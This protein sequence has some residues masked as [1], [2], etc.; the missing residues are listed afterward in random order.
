M[1]TPKFYLTLNQQPRSPRGQ[2]R[3][4]NPPIHRSPSNRADPGTGGTEEGTVIPVATDPY[5]GKTTYAR[6]GPSVTT[7]DP[8]LGAI[9]WVAPQMLTMIDWALT[10][11][12]PV[13]PNAA[14]LADIP[15]EGIRTGEITG[16]RLWWALDYSLYSIVHQEA[17]SPNEVKKGN[18]NEMVHLYAR[19]GVYCFNTLDEAFSSLHNEMEEYRHYQNLGS[20]YRDFFA[21]RWDNP[22]IAVGTVK[23]WGEVVEHQRGYRAENAKISSIYT[24]VSLKDRWADDLKLKQFRS[25]YSVGAKP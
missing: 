3:K 4:S 2:H 1:K 18:L 17:W 23:L 6:K 22:A 7:I 20:A 10:C 24:I 13:G 9:Y 12:I 14:P 15:S 21:Y 16:Y 8:P 19:G 11:V 5:A 25:L